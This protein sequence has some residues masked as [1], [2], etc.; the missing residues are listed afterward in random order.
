MTA[1]PVTRALILECAGEPTKLILLSGD[2]AIASLPLG[3]ADAVALASD[4]L[5]AARR[6]MG[7]DS[8]R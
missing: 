7:R 6:R 2:T 4:L 5:L 8:A 3:P 1:I